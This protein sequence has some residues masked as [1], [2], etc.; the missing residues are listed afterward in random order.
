VVVALLDDPDANIQAS[1]VRQLRARRVPDA[2]QRLVALLDSSLPEVRDAARSS[3]AEF[4][5]TRYRTMFDVLD[6]QSARTT[7]V[8]VHKVDNTVQQKLAEE[9]LAPSV[10]TKLRGIE[11]AIA[12]EATDDVRQQLVD[13]ASHENLSVRKEAIS[14]LAYCHGEP[15]IAT[16]KRAANDPIHSIAEAA[17]DSL[18][19]LQSGQSQIG[20]QQAGG[21]V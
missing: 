12:M 1:A 8:L 14:A 9:L 2:L 7:G 3:L 5:F 13:L 17:R 20:L 11:M 4:N 19:K 18:A 16:M 6:E 15:V 10:T 21:R